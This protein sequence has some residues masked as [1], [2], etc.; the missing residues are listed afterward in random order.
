M[1]HSIPIC[2]W[3]WIPRDYFFHLCSTTSHQSHL[4]RQNHKNKKK[5]RKTSTHLRRR[6]GCSLVASDV[7]IE[8][9][10]QRSPAGSIEVQ[11]SRG[12]PE[13]QSDTMDS[14]GPSYDPIVF[15][16]HEPSLF[17]VKKLKFSVIAK[18]QCIGPRHTQT[19]PLHTLKHHPSGIRLA[20]P[21]QGG[22]HP[23]TKAP[24]NWNPTVTFTKSR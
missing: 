16:G 9:R 7:I 10:F 12:R 23:M 22:T 1:K 20:Q 19:Q 14:H 8:S 4:Q 21:R 24:E 11:R 6:H 13:R 3:I 18:K 15:N 2:K 17:Y 5:H